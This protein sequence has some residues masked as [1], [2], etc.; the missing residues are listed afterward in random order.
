MT[1]TLGGF[2]DDVLAREPDR[3]VV[4]YAPSDRITVRQRARE[5]RAATRLAAKRLV[6]L[7]VGK[8]MRVGLLCPNRPEW[9]AVA[10]GALRLGAVLVPF[11]TL[12]KR[13]EIAYG[14]T[15]GDVQMLITVPGFLRHDYLGTLHD[16]LPELA[17]STPGRLRA[18]SAPALRGVWL[19]GNE[20]GASA[21]SSPGTP[22]FDA[23]ASDVD[24]T[25]LDALQATVSPTDLAT[26]FFT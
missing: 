26:I 23:V 12:W 3:E 24:D 5:L 4:A 19:L 7:G 1:E 9:L 21:P 10:F 8:G 25:L 20:S 17:A 2:L 11:S 18:P 6:A 16:L 22:P 14:L 13:D 15:H